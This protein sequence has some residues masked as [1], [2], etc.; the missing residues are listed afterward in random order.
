[1]ITS[2]GRSVSFCRDAKDHVIKVV[3]KNAVSLRPKGSRK[4]GEGGVPG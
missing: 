1:M 3:A 4:G 2:A